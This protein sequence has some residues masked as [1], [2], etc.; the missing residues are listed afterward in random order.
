MAKGTAWGGDRLA[1]GGLGLTGCLRG[2]QPLVAAQE[3]CVECP[4]GRV[5]GNRVRWPWGAQRTGTLFGAPRDCC[6][7]FLLEPLTSG[8]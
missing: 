4:Q 8:T 6:H 2:T 3:T 7:P 5:K 1:G